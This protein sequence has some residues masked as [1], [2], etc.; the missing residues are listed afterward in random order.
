MEFDLYRYDWTEKKLY[1]ASVPINLT[2]KVVDF[3]I[4]IENSSDL[5]AIGVANR[6]AKLIRWDGKA[7]TAEIVESNLFSVEQDPKYMTNWWHIAVA[8][9]K[10]RF[11]GGTYRNQLCGVSQTAN[12]SLYRYTKKTGVEHL[13]GDFQ[14][15]GGMEWNTDT[16]TFYLVDVCRSNINAFDWSPETGHISTYLKVISIMRR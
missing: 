12:A 10:G 15:V 5:F 7:T 16:N 3:L 6:V 1:G 14:I 2:P 13:Q 11:F 8:D 4:P 9:P